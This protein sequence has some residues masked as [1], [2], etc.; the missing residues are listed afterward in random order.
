MTS[1][2]WA[3]L[4]AEVINKANMRFTDRDTFYKISYQDLECSISKDNE[5]DIADFESN[6]KELA[7]KISFNEVV[8]QFEKRDKTLKLACLEAPCDVTSGIATALLKIPGTAGS[9]D[10]RW[11]SSGTAW[12]GG[13][14]NSDDRILG[15]WFTDEDNILGYGAG[16]V[17]GSYTDDELPAENQGN[18]IPKNPSYLTVQAIGGYGFAPSGLYIKIMAQ[19]GGTG[20]F[21][22][23]DFYVNFEWGK[24]D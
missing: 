9:G 22:G 3:E 7:N 6:Y 20:P 24:S 18:Y 1:L 4:K 14:W 15:V 2:T 5:T 16:F 19:K 13:E 12:L 23:I 11:L 8:T 17:V 21:T 10:G